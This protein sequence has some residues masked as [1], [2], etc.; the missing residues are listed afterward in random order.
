MMRRT[1]ITAFVLVASLVVSL[2]TVACKDSGG[3]ATED[4][5]KAAT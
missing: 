4:W 5:A 3:D 1:F 2:G